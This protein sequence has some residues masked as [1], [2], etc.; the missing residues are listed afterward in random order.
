VKI[1]QEPDGLGVRFICTLLLFL[2][3]EKKISAGQNMMKYATNH[4]DEFKSPV[5]AWLVG[6]MQCISTQMTIFACIWFIST[7]TQPI[8][9]ILQFVAF[10]T[11]T[12]F[13]NFYYNSIPW[14]VKANL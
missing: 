9:M 3:I 12:K 2:T 7:L 11:I 8:N 6:M 5:L 4:P 1:P 10:L 13:D 14:E